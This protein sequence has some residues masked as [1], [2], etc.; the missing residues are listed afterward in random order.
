M[1][2]NSLTLLTGRLDNIEKELNKTND[3]FNRLVKQ[4]IYLSKKLFGDIEVDGKFDEHPEETYYYTSSLD[5][6]TPTNITI[7]GPGTYNNRCAI[8]EL[9]RPTWAGDLKAWKVFDKLTNVIE[10]IP[11]IKYKKIDEYNIIE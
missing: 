7:H 4:N 10:K 6:D 3:I 8:K 1:D 11:N 9:N 2:Y 5:N